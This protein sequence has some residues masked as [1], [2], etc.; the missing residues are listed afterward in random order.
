MVHPMLI[1]AGCTVVGLLL[2][3]TLATTE[4][5]LNQAMPESAQLLDAF[6]TA[7]DVVK[8]FEVYVQAKSEVYFTEGGK[9][10]DRDTSK[11]A[12]LTVFSPPRVSW[13]QSRQLYSRGWR[14]VEKFDPNT[15]QPVEVYGADN[16][17]ERILFVR[18][19]QGVVRRAG[20]KG[21]DWGKDYQETFRTLLN[22]LP[23]MHVFRGRTKPATVW[24]ED[25]YTV[26]EI[27]PGLGNSYGNWG[28]RVFADPSAKFFP[29]KTESYRIRDGE[30][31]LLS[32]MTVTERKQIGPDLEVP[33]KAMTEFF[34]TLKGSERY[35]QVMR[36]DE[37]IVDVAR[38][39][40]NQPI[41]DDAFRVAF[42]SGLL[43][44]DQ[45]RDLA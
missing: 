1:R 41:A 26:I 45:I 18:D 39:Q 40:W 33:I 34:C 30:Q 23:T 25:R 13:S 8:S 3:T 24:R 31:F 21:M 12:E 4:G 10:K 43:V 9:T 29:A 7:I 14:R 37:L 44:N 19:Q 5:Q 27:E 35:Q 17:T 28:F 38:S 6:E 42:P 32:R 11:R 20:S 16:E 2:S 36:K 22:G 15:G